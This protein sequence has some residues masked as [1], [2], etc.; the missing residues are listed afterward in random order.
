MLDRIRTHWT[1]LALIVL[2]GLQLWVGIIWILADARVGDGVCCS[3]T[4][5]VMGILLAD[6]TDQLGRPWG[7]DR[8]AAGRR[9]RAIKPIR[10]AAARMNKSMVWLLNPMPAD[11]PLLASG[12]AMR[13]GAKLFMAACAIRPEARQAGFMEK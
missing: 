7:G 12:S 9:G 13:S 3:L 8:G 6:G 4:A 2:M 10:R 11:N 5:P 1:L